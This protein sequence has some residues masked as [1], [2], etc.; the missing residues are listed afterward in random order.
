MNRTTVHAARAFAG[1]F[2]NAVRTATHHPPR[3]GVALGGGFARGIAHV[4]VLRV[5]ER[6]GIPIHCIAGV[7]A[8]SIVAAAYASGAN[9]P[10]IGVAGCSMRFNDVARWTIG[11]MGIAGNNPMTR[12]LERLLRT[13]SFE[14]MR[15]P[16]AVVAT[17]LVTGDPIAFRGPGDV[18][19]PVRASCAYPGLFQ[20]VRH[21]G[22][23]LVDGAMSMDVPA[24]AL[25]EMG[26][27]FV[28]SVTLPAAAPGI[29]PSNAFQVVN[30][31]FQ[32]L[33][34]RTETEWRSLSDLVIEPDTAGVAWDGFG[35]GE[36]LIAAGEAAAER[37]LAPF[38]RMLSANGSRRTRP[39]LL[40]GSPVEA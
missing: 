2:W 37:A 21:H 7:S 40:V 3:I 35:C 23:W 6:Y 38:R 28:V 32:I 13:T 20:P 36:Q 27:T 12:F 1:A 39:L 4:G 9:L 11:K 14:E 33:Q 25:R 22:R 34:T 18:C 17:D 24:R 15:I 5:F 29:A 31:C 26:A 8:G 30:R 10:A 19:L 16:L